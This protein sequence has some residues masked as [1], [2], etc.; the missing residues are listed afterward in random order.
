MEIQ[1]KRERVVEAASRRGVLRTEDLSDLGVSTSYISD[2][3]E[4]GVLK[5]L[6]RGLF[7]LPDYPVT[8]NHSLVEVAAYAPKSVVCL[9]SA[10]QFHGI[11]TQLPH[12]VW[13][14]L[15]NYSRPP[16]VPTVAVE[17]VRMGE[18]SLNAGVEEHR[19]EGVPVRIFSAAKTVADC[20]KFR[21]VVGTEVALEALKDVL[22]RRMVTRD[23]LYDYAVVDRVWNVM[24]PYLEVIR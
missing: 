3:A 23:Q 5:K 9:A 24:R 15:P 4:R 19:I 18:A 12:A 11:G 7:S 6:G 1:T 21:S 22:H 10:L 13:I 8:E 2:L 17:V 16:K 14:A 20:F